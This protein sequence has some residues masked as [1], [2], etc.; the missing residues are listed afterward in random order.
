MIHMFG[1]MAL[2]REV[3]VFG[4]RMVGCGCRECT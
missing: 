3:E 2:R 4:M 1:W